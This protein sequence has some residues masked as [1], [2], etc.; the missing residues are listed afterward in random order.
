MERICPTCKTIED[1]P[2]TFIDKKTGLREVI[3]ASS[4]ELATLRAW[5]KNPNLTLPLV[6]RIR[7]K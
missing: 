1:Y 7:D 3:Y 5:K 2:F 4:T 6:R